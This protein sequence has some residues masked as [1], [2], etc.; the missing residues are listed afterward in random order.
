MEIRN[1]DHHAVLQA[2]AEEEESGNN[3]GDTMTHD[4]QHV[5]CP[6]RQCG[7]EGGGGSKERGQ[8]SCS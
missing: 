8:C 1:S 2:R 6:R 7:M 5:K 3:E 4:C